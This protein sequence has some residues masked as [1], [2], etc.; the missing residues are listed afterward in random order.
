M[1]EASEPAF[2]AALPDLA[3]SRVS[4]I[5]LGL[6]GA[7][8]ALDL[9]GHCAEIVGVSRSPATLAYA[10]EHQIVNRIVSFETALECDLIV[11]AAP[12]RTILQQLTQISRLSPDSPALA[13]DRPALLIDLGS[14]KTS[15]VHAMQDLPPRFY[16][17]GGHPMCGK[18][19]AG[20]QHAEAGLYRDKIFVLSPLPRTS[21]AALALAQQLIAR[22]G[23]RPLVLPA[24]EQDTL[25]AMISH[26]PYAAAVAL[27][28][29]A[30]VKAAQRSDDR[31]WTVAASGFRDTS[32]VAASDVTMW[33]DI[34][35]T[36]QSAALDALQLYRAELDDLIGLI[37]AGDEAALRAFLEPAQQQRGK[38]FR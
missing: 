13:S 5:G 26:L 18:E 33:L 24:Q 20:I 31:L 15:I 4:I 23:S 16:P 9:R 2:T 17:V 28:R 12:V 32:R 37:Q 1:M 38:L 19:V 6:M 25:V 14:T 22:L 35:L 8:L 21:P 27:V 34:L 3:G 10:I 11:L 30:M 29:A 7:S 36:N